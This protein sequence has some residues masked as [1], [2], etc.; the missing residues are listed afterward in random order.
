MSPTELAEAAIFETGLG[1]IDAETRLTEP[2]DILE[3]CG[4]LIT[5]SIFSKFADR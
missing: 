5:Y 2:L 3:I 4:S 1:Y